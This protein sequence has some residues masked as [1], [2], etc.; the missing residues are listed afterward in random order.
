M[1]TLLGAARCLLAV[2][3]ARRHPSPVSDQ[4][5][6]LLATLEAR[7][8][9]PTTSEAEAK[10]KEPAA[11]FWETAAEPPAE[12]EAKERDM[13]D[14]LDVHAKERDIK[15]GLSSSAPKPTHPIGPTFSALGAYRIQSTLSPTQAQART[16]PLARRHPLTIRRYPTYTPALP[17]PLTPP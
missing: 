10:A 7:A 11:G 15:R 4:R 9:L 2:N 6:K 16:N 13:F 1:L 14:K 5:P 12:A 3:R 8:E 17:P